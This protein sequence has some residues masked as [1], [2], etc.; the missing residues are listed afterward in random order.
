MQTGER[1]LHLRL[2]TGFLHHP[3]AAGPINQIPEQR[4]LTRT[5][6]T[7]QHQRPTLPGTHRLRQAVQHAALS[8]TANQLHRTR[9]AAPRL[10]ARCG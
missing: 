8:P 9:T 3:A 6:L 7:A 2:H 10:N 5:R 4:S 1:R